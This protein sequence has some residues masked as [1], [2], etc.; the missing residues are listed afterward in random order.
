MMASSALEGQIFQAA[1]TCLTT[2]LSVAR[3]L[4]R[5]LLLHPAAAYC[6]WTVKRVVQPLEGLLLPDP[7]LLG[8]ILTLCR[9]LAS[10]RPWD[11]AILQI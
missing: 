3:L 7:L 8:W 9:R 2:T 1:T 5:L 6:Q 11:L 4:C 10:S